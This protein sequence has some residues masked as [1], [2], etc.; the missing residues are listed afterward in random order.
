[1]AKTA[2]TGTKKRRRRSQ[3]PVA[4]IYFTTLLIFLGVFG[5][6][7]KMI[8]NKLS[9]KHGA[10]ANISDTYIDSYNTLYAR[11]NAK[12]ALADLFVL[13]ICPEQARVIVVPISSYT[14]ST[15]DEGKNFREVYAEGGIRQ[16]QTAVDNTFG[17]STNYYATVT[18]SSF[19]D[20]CDIVGGIT[21]APE[22][23]LYYLDKNGDNDISLRPNKAVALSGKQIRLILQSPVFSSGKQGNMEFLGVALTELINNAFDQVEMTSASLDNIYSKIGS[24]SATNLSENEYKEHRAYIKAMLE[25]QIR[26]AETLTPSGTWSDEKHFTPSNEFK[27]QLYDVM[28]AT[29]SQAKSGAKTEDQ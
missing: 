4:L 9:T 18:N 11:V 12:D 3:A 19:E 1:M 24:N 25:K 14:V 27:Q 6:F 29:K 15:V 7:A 8:V 21:Y 20:I 13:R 28:E 17:I 2:K 23:E 10:D 16:L 5:L 26:P 22:E